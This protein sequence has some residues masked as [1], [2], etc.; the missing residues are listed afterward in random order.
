M[1]GGP[2]CQTG[3]GAVRCPLTLNTKCE[4]ARHV[5]RITLPEIAPFHRDLLY[6]VHWFR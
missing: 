5:S 2:F 3:H 6:V 1:E 4:A